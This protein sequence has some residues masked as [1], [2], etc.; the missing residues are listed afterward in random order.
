M[1]SLRERLQFFMHQYNEA[2]RGSGLDL[3]F[4]EDAIISLIKVCLF[5]CLF[6][7]IF[8]LILTYSLVP[9]NIIQINS[10]KV[11]MKFSII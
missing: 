11:L 10:D 6:V 3:V 1:E 4:F 7:C 2:T 5:V 9:P 8:P